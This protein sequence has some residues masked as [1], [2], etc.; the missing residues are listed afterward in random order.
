M[1]QL[2][3]SL[4]TLIAPEMG[5]AAAALGEPESKVS[6]ASHAILA[7]L[8]AHMAK[9][10]NAEG[11]SASLKAAGQSNILHDLGHIFSGKDTKSEETATNNFLKT[12]LG[13][14]VDHFNAGIASA[15]GISAGNAG[16]LT[17]MIG[18]AVSAFLGKQVHEGTS[19]SDL[20]KEL[21]KE[22]HSFLSA[23]PAGV[24][25]ALGLSAAHHEANHVAHP[26]A[27]HESH[28]TAHHTHAAHTQHTDKT[29][30]VH[31]MLTEEDRKRHTKEIKLPKETKEATQEIRKKGGLGWLLWLLLAIVLLLLLIFGWRSCHRRTIVPVE[32]VVVE[33]PVV[34]VAPV[35]PEGQIE[36]TLPNGVK[37]NALPGGM[38]AKM[39]D[40]LNSDLYKNATDAELKNHWFE[41]E[42][43]DFVRGSSS[44]Y[45]NPALA[46]IRLDNIGAILKAF[47][48]ANIRIGGFA[49]KTGTTGYNLELSRARA[50]F[51][52]QYLDAQEGVVPSRM[53]TEGFGEEYAN[54]PVTATAE[55][56]ASDRDI[57]FRFTKK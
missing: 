6:T 24:A 1:A 17:A 13:G 5:K 26:A 27:H 51:I 8:L 37:L 3:N 9:H 31:R 46:K 14:K 23:I 32:G 39:I 41:F 4:K 57:A 12:L 7:G 19:A 11:L 21:G 40:F 42:D 29:H 55:E 2:F 44:E 45:M 35:V 38:E 30:T 16:R 49:D 53:T 56:A 15:S 36:L 18:S 54:F 48:T 25:T 22:E 28:P 47:P 34:A 20:V 10:G 50:V 52:D 43:V 33:T